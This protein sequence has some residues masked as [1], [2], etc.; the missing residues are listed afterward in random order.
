MITINGIE[1]HHVSGELESVGQ[2]TE[3]ISQQG[4]DY[5]LWRNVGLRGDYV[6][7]ITMR[8]YNNVADA[9]TA[10]KSAKSIQGYS[11]SVTDHLGVVFPAVHIQ[12]VRKVS[13]KVSALVVGD[14]HSTVSGNA[15]VLVMR[16]IM[17]VNS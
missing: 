13:S 11:V 6:E 10:Y 14:K 4:V 17:V 5:R 8:D 15:V 1:Y 9:N 16:W 3:D 12:A 2:E 7:I